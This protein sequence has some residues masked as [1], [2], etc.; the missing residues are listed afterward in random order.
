MLM[1]ASALSLLL[2]S[3]FG[4]GGQGDTDDGNSDAG[5]GAQFVSD[6]GAGASIRIQVFGDLD[7][8]G[9][10]DFIVQVL[11]PQ[12]NP[13]PAVGIACDSEN[14]I[15]ILEPSAGGVAISQTAVNGIM[16]G[17]LGGVTPG[18]YVLEC[19]AEQGFNLIDRT[20]IFI[21]GN[22]PAGFEGFPGAA[23]G[24]LGGGLLVDDEDIAPDPDVDGDPTTSNN[25]AIT[26]IVFLDGPE[27]TFF[28]DT[29]QNPDCDGDPS[30]ND[31]EPF[32]F[33]T[34][35]ISYQNP[36]AEA[37]Q[38]QSVEFRPGNGSGAVSSQQGNGLI[39]P[40]NTTGQIDGPLTEGAGSNQTF[41]GTGSP[42]TEGTYNIEFTIRSVGVN[43]GQSYT[44]TDSAVATFAPVNRCN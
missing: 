30:T 17:V 24:N 27:E 28:L 9:T 41:A 11:D 8:G 12:G 6:G 7:V 5:I 21:D 36:R 18:S 26:D 33:K 29:T 42:T 23:G 3:T 4:C 39:I 16:S 32:F 37:L 20:T 22:F 34:Y 2:L 43:S 13:I 10:T 31:P 25:P 15:A 1:A 14:G 35:V 44:L 38:V 19:R 40:S